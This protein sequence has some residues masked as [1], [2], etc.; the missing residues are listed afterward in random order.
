MNLVSKNGV[1]ATLFF[2]IGITY[3]YYDV[4]LAERMVHCHNVWALGLP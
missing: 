3:L 4:V 2:T 1:F